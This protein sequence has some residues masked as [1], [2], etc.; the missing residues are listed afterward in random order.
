[1]T[2]RERIR[3]IVR[4]EP[5]DRIGL[6]EMV[7]WPETITDW[8]KEGL[9]E[10]EDPNTYLGMD[11][12]ARLWIDVTL[13]LEPQ[14]LE[15]DDDFRI[16]TDSLGVTKKVW[17]N[18]YAPPRELDHLIKTV[19]DWRKY[20][21]RL[22]PSPERYSEE[23][24]EIYK[25]GG[26]SGAFSFIHAW[27]PV[28][29]VMHLIGYDKALMAVADSP[30]FIREIMADYTAFLKAQIEVTESEG[31]TLDGLWLNA[32]I[33]YGNGMI[34]SPEFYKEVVAP[35]DQVF[36]DLCKERD[37]PL[38]LHCC[39]RVTELIPLLIEVGY[40]CLHPLE[41]RAGNDIREL[42][43]LYGDRMTFI[44]NIAVETLGS[45][46]ESIEEEIKAKIPVAMQGGGYIF[47]SDHSVPPSVTLE[48]YKYAVECARD[49]G[50]YS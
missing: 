5:A 12:M 39:G 29:F 23:C 32:D 19:Q 16:E 9:P 49:L 14:L 15:E 10:G 31:V 18:S 50:T 46:K 36:A 38:F 45:S 40:D 6:Y 30:E 20:K 22:K 41:A 43:K 26:S 24:R 47:G 33:C 28:W 13:R 11:D 42:K 4:H 2:S 25:R 8:N 3:K 44:G 7:F 1:M 37:I 27:E 48:N 21:D 34:F 17:K 35:Y